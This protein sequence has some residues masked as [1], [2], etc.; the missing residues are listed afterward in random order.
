MR[1]GAFLGGLIF[2]GLA[3]AAIGILTAPKS[4]NEL[5]RE[6]VDA[7]DNFYRKAQYEMEELAEK[8]EDLTERV[9]SLKESAPDHIRQAMHQAQHAIEDFT[10]AGHKQHKVEAAVEVTQHSQ[11]VLQQTKSPTD[12]QQDQ[13]A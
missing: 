10:P 2:G 12:L 3:G 9:E 5:R 7:S 13:S 11:E 1:I 8:L 4:G 6:L